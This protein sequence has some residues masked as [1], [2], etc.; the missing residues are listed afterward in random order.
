MV[1]DKGQPMPI[2]VAMSNSF[3]FGGTNATV[4]FRK[5]A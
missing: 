3:G 1:R 2:D 5:V 4:I